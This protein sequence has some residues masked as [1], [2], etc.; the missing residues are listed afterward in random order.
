MATFKLEVRKQ[1]GK[2]QHR[3]WSADKTSPDFDGPT[4]DLAGLLEAV[5]KS[6]EGAGVTKN[7][8]VIFRQVGYSNRE[9][10]R[11]AVRTAKY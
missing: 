9:E 11:F 3:L 1:F 10:L 8:T 5:H 2:L 4:G 7:D 6:L